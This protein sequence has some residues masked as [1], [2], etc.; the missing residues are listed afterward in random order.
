MIVKCRLGYH[1]RTSAEQGLNYGEEGGQGSL[2]ECVARSSFEP[3]VGMDHAFLDLIPADRRAANG[4]GEFVCKCCLAKCASWSGHDHQ[5]WNAISHQATFSRFAASP[6]RTSLRSPGRA[7]R[8]LRVLRIETLDPRPGALSLAPTRGRGWCGSCPTNCPTS[9]A[10]RPVRHRPSTTQLRPSSPMILCARGASGPRCPRLHHPFGDPG[11][12]PHPPLG[13]ESGG[14][15]HEPRSSGRP[16]ANW[17]AP[18][19]K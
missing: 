14:G 12:K 13:A 10:C 15:L 17:S 8:A 6:L 5:R 1:R 19:P 2:S 11:L 7:S 9:V 18:A 16:Q 3:W 4:P